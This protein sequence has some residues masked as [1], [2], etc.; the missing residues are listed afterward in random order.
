MGLTVDVASTGKSPVGGESVEHG[1]DWAARRCGSEGKTA[2]STVIFPSWVGIA[3]VALA[4]R[5]SAEELA[6][7]HLRRAR[8]ALLVSP[9]LTLVSAW[10]LAVASPLTSAARHERWQAPT[11]SQRAWLERAGAVAAHIEI[12]GVKI[13]RDTGWGLSRE[14]FASLPNLPDL[15]G[16]ELPIISRYF[17]TPETRL[18]AAR[19]SAGWPYPAF[20]ATQIDADD[21]RGLVRGV[22]IMRVSGAIVPDA[23]LPGM[24]A[25]RV[26]PFLPLWPGVIANTF[27]FAALLFLALSAPGACTALVRWRRRQCVACGYQV[28]TAERCS[29]CGAPQP[30]RR[31]AGT[32]R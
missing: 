4:G 2:R 23:P 30:A 12:D 11:V 29:E 1:S 18:C 8:L 21:R 27:M 3:T 22:Q 13:R 19:W 26:L 14:C 15:G 7:D 31:G 10:G 6:M 28:S 16:S 9:L 24:P 17:T 5:V 32:G 25:G 20:T